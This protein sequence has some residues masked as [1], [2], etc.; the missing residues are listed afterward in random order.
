[1]IKICDK[2]RGAHAQISLD[3]GTVILYC[4][5]TRMLTNVTLRSV[6]IDDYL[7]QLYHATVCHAFVQMFNFR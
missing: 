2:I 5:L 3:I 6:A 4:I 1:M 7:R